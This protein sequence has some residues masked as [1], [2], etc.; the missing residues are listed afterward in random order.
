[1]K[2]GRVKLIGFCFNF[3]PPDIARFRG[4]N[5]WAFRAWGADQ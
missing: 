4:W 2:S 1:V 3:R 5:H